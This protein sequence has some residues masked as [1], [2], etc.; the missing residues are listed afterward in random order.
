MRVGSERDLI[1]GD[2]L[3]ANGDVKV[4]VDTELGQF[5]VS[6]DKADVVAVLRHLTRIFEL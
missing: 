5:D 4:T 1:I 2:K 3:D 6:I